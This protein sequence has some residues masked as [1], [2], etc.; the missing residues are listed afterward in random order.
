MSLTLG[1]KLRQAREERGISVGEV[2][3][4]TRI[5]PHYIESIEND[6]YKTLPGGI[7]NKGFIKSYARYVGFDEQEALGD[8]SK[9]M[10]SQNEGIAPDEPRTYR[11]EVL[12]DDNYSSSRLPT[13]ILAGVIL[14]LMTAGVLYL[15]NYLTSRSEQPVANSI[16]TPT[17]VETAPA[18]NT[19]AAP[20][21]AG[22][23]MGTVKISFSTG[24]QPIWLSSTVDG[25]TSS[26][27]VTPEKP[28]VFEPKE[29]IRLSYS[30][31]LAQSARLSINDKQV[32]LPQA[33]ANPKRVPIDVEINQSNL[34]EIWQSGQV[35]AAGVPTH[36][37]TTATP[38]P[39]PTGTPRPKP[40]ATPT[41]AKPPATP[42]SAGTPKPRP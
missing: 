22:P 17:P 39:A 40:S 11:P 5:S 1:Q 15:L 24:N 42:A 31:S 32:T 34:A 25:K 30:K 10:A 13:L 35:A 16:A 20:V 3:E 7:F 23:A 14:A 38:R 4:Q 8:Y 26:A 21:A 28:V 29:S 37:P 36:E 6:D 27:V 33:P 2:S 12:T 41:A 19:V 9:L 18:A